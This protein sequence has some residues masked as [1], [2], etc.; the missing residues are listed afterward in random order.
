VQVDGNLRNTGSGLQWTPSLSPVNPPHMKEEDESS[1][2]HGDEGTHNILASN[3][4]KRKRRDNP[5]T[6]R[7]NKEH[8][9]NS[10][11][12]GK[13]YTKNNSKKYD[14]SKYSTE[15]KQRTD[16]PSDERD[17]NSQRK[18]K[19]DHNIHHS[20]LSFLTQHKFHPKHNQ[21]SY[22]HQ[23]D[24][25]LQNDDGGLSRAHSMGSVHLNRVMHSSAE[26]PSRGK[27]CPQRVL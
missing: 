17:S 22:K 20:R 21:S 5:Q 9:S 11:K 2:L 18:K 25:S 24:P 23:P 10:E 6:K 15:D 4:F 27:E 16:N 8:S 1:S 12:Q 13:N 26:M 7:K 14:K 19:L 3:N